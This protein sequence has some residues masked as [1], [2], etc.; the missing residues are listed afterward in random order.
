[1]LYG[2]IKTTE[3]TSISHEKIYEVTDLWQTKVVATWCIGNLDVVAR[4]GFSGVTLVG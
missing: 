3:T 2:I 1:M 4:V